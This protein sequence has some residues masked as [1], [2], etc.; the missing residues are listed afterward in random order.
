MRV[1]ILIT[2]AYESTNY[3]DSN[4]I[5][6]A[7]HEKMLEAGFQYSS[8]LFIIDVPIIKQAFD[9]ARSTIEGLENHIPFEER[10]LPGYLKDFYGFKLEDAVNLALPDAA[11]IK[12]D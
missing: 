7:I 5:W 2:L 4:F 8:R 12:V 3:E 11:T 9:L 10:R 6:E 1:A